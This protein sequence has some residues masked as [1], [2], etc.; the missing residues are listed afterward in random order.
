MKNIRKKDIFKHR[1][2]YDLYMCKKLHE[3]KGYA[4]FKN[5]RTK[6]VIPVYSLFNF[7]YKCHAE[8]WLMKLL[9]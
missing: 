4:E 9:K 8:N 6:E 3:K 5:L 1:I 2:T 7:E